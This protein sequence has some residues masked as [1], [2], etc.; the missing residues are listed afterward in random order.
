LMTYGS[1][2]YH[3]GGMRGIEPSKYPDSVTNSN[4]YRQDKWRAS[5][6]RS[7]TYYLWKNL[8]QD[9]LKDSEGKYYTMAYDQA[10]M[11]PLLEMS[12]DRSVYIEENLYVY[13]KENP[14][15]VDKIKAQQQ[16]QTAQEIRNKK[17]YS[18]L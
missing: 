10:I 8:N 11:L 14:L 15:N 6:L 7:F 18:K 4:S 2:V 9:D 12:A 3:P 5:H 17:P 16:H 1:Y 13:N